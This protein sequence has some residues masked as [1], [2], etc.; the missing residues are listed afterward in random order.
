M[1][2]GRYVAGQ[3]LP[4]WNRTILDRSV[5]RAI[6]RA[7]GSR[8]VVAHSGVLPHPPKLDGTDSHLYFGWY[9][10]DER[11]LP[12]FAAGDPPAW[13][14]SSPSSAPRR[15]PRTPT[16]WSPSAGPT[17]T[18]SGSADHHDLQKAVFDR[19]RARRR[20]SPPS[21]TGAPATAGYQALV[22]KHHVEQLRRLKY[23]PT[24]GFAVFLLNDAHPAVTWSVLDHDRAAK[25]GYHALIEACRPVIVVA[26]RL[27]AGRRRRAPPLALDVHVVSRPP[28]RRRAGRGHGPPVLAGRRSRRGGGG[29]T[30]AADACARVGIVRF[31]VPDAPGG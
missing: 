18:G 2:L 30:V 12:G 19:R 14:A 24:G 6:E 1:T 22:V 7:D 15:C 27:P 10:G 11:D 13:C 21:T 8:P 25:A 28:R 3:E 23:R 31:V 4:T 17:S 29:A 9:Y 16:S 20:P 5:K 26:D